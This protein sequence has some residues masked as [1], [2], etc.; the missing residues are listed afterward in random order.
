MSG[1]IYF[2]AEGFVTNI[3]GE[4][5]LSRVGSHVDGEPGL[6]G[7]LLLTVGAGDESVSGVESLV[8]R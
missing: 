7:E 4:R 8:S 1:Y 5:P 3:A 2:E 6:R